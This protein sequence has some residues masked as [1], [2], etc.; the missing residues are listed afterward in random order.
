MAEGGIFILFI[1]FAWREASGYW[2]GHAT[3]NFP[4]TIVTIVFVLNSYVH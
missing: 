2:R 4:A 3:S 1:L